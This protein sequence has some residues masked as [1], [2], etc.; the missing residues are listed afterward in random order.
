MQMP[1]GPHL[2]PEVGCTNTLEA[3][4]SAQRGRRSLAI[5]LSGLTTAAISANT[6]CS[7]ASWMYRLATGVFGAHP[8]LISNAVRSFASA[9]IVAA[10]ARSLCGWN[11]PSH[12]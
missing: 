8:I 10:T 12:P 2:T 9:A 7:C 11:E 1:P 6:S 4:N 3:S 5:A